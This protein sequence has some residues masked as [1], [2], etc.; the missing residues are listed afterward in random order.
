MQC[1]FVTRRTKVTISFVEIENMQ[2]QELTAHQIE[3]I[4]TKHIPIF[5]EHTKH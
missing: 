2:K 1:R 5:T 4:F 3:R